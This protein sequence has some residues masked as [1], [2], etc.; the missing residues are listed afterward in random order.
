MSTQ[1][2][3]K[4]DSKKA[5]IV[6]LGLGYVGLPLA[7]NFAKVGFKVYGVDNDRDRV[8][9]ICE[10]QSYILDVTQRQVQQVVD[11]GRL[12]ATTEFDVI[13]TADVIIICVPTPLKRK[14]TPDIS[15]IF[16][17]FPIF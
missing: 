15:Y 6:V 11:N 17:P 1:L 3:E 5:Q 7:I 2:R 4:I 8:H 10:K 9:K 13:K 14:Y 12:V 16:C